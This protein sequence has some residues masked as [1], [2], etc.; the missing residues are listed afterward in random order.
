MGAKR[1]GRLRRTNSRPKRSVCVWS[2]QCLR[3]RGVER[4]EWA[5][6]R[7]NHKHIRLDRVARHA[8]LRLLHRL[9]ETEILLLDNGVEHNFMRHGRADRATGAE[10]LLDLRRWQQKFV[11]V[12][13][14]CDVCASGAALL[15]RSGSRSCRT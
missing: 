1:G 12:C 13:D 4:G 9:V 10:A 11:S 5:C 7:G 3:V 14:V 8:R 15:R 2:G 6:L